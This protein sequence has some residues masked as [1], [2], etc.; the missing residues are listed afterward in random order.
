VQT[1]RATRRAWRL[2]SA[3]RDGQFQK[4]TLKGGI[5]TR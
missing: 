3:R 4:I 5:S 1:A 2:I